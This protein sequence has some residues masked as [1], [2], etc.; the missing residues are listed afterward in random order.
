MGEFQRSRLFTPGPLK[1]SELAHK[2]GGARFVVLTVEPC[3]MSS[4]KRG[5]HQK[6]KEAG[7]SAGL[8]THTPD[9]PAVSNT[10]LIFQEKV[11]FEQRKI[12]GMQRNASHRWTNTTI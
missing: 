12:G 5:L 8:E 10:W 2:G 1:F 4:P 11:V 7:A 6:V 3:P 9:N